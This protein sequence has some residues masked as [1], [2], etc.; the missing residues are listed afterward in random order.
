MHKPDGATFAKALAAEGAKVIAANTRDCKSVTVP[1]T[2]TPESHTR[3]VDVRD[4]KSVANMMDETESKFGRLDILVN[5]AA[6]GSNIPPI[7]I[8]QIPGEVWD[9]FMAV[10]V[11]RDRC[12][13]SNFASAFE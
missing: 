12:K 10:N 8:E 5:N 11:R 9:D 3:R 4:E 13:R 1:S 7:S 2:R 6:I